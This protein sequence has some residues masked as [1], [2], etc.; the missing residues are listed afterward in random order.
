M[1]RSTL[2]SFITRFLP[3]LPLAVVLTAASCQGDGET[4]DGSASDDDDTGADDDTTEE[5]PACSDS[6]DVP[7]LETIETSLPAEHDPG[8]ILYRTRFHATGG[9]PAYAH[10]AVPPSVAPGEGWPVIVLNHGFI[11]FARHCGTVH[12]QGD[13]GTPSSPALWAASEEAVVLA[14]DPFGMGDEVIGDAG[15]RFHYGVNENGQVIL[16]AMNWLLHLQE[17]GIVEVRSQGITMAGNCVGTA[18]TLWA[19]AQY[20]DDHG[21]YKSGGAFTIDRVVLGSPWALGS[22]LTEKAEGLWDLTLLDDGVGAVPQ[23]TLAFLESFETTGEEFVPG[24]PTV[25][26]DEETRDLIRTLNEQLCAE[27][28]EYKWELLYYGVDRGWWC[29][30]GVE[31]VPTYGEFLAAF[32]HPTFY[33][34]MAQ[35]AAGQEP[36]AEF[37]DMF[38]RRD[39]WSL[40]LPGADVLGYQ[41]VHGS[42]DQFVTPVI[43]QG[44]ETLLVE[45]VGQPVHRREFANADHLLIWNPGTTIANSGAC[46]EDPVLDECNMDAM[47]AAREYLLTGVQIP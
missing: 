8:V 22:Y 39:G 44:T 33:G 24:A 12:A 36:E 27:T 47:R 31:C 16:D 41:L 10:I 46:S 37:T 4:D 21:G 3:V 11:G 30:T 32:L 14:P 28:M 35:I 9:A 13:G 23:N 38:T 29:D 34:Q 17:R 43:V 25:F 42:M 20:E 7:C 45:N 18:N 19:L 6:P 5:L 1:A 40:D 2:V 15:L 26:I